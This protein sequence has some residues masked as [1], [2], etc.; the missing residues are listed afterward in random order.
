MKAFNLFIT[1]VIFF[2]ISTAAYSGP[3]EVFKVEVNKSCPNME[4]L[5]IKK[6][7]ISLV[8]ESDFSCNSFFTKKALETCSSLTCTGLHNIYLQAKMSDSG[9]VIGGS[10]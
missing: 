4:N 8:R 7:M 3:F 5:L 1:I 2:S 9:N 10:R 6:V